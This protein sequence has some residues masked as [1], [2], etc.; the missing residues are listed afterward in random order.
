MS[1]KQKIIALLEEKDY[2][3]VKELSKAE[4]AVIRHLISLT[5]DRKTALCW[6]AIEAIG[7]VSSSMGAE[8]ARRL[9]QRVL[10][11]M[12]DE[13][14][15]NPWS[16]PDI[17][18]EIVRAHPDALSDI[19]PIIASFHDEEIFRQGALRALGRIAEIRL[20]LVAPFRDMIAGYLNHP[21]AG[22]RGCAVYALGRAFKPLSVGGGE[23]LK[24]ILKDEAA[25]YFYMDGEL[26]RTTVAALAREALERT[27]SQSGDSARPEA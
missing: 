19:A 3:S 12:R 13:S 18:G 4:P 16:A 7:V 27:P 5:Y 20:S 21:D 14:G 22:V 2:A 8:E 26:K 1:L 9:S 24:E 15:G 6:R 17:L 11:M 23:I 10:W 25:L